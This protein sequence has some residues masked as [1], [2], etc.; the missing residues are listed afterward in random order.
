MLPKEY[1]LNASALSNLDS[2]CLPV[3]FILSDIPDSTSLSAIAL[4][5]SSSSHYFIN[6]CLIKSASLYTHSILPVS[7]RLFDSSQ[8]KTI[9]KVVH[10]IP[11]H[12]LSGNIMPLTFYVTPLDSICLVV[13]GYSWL[14]CY[15]LGID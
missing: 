9:T 13:L 2:F 3:S 12:F 14:T 1:H 7:L 8:G 4:I 11:L 5:D 10:E 15:N 6:S